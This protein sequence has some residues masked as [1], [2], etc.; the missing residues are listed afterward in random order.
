MRSDAARDARAQAPTDPMI[1]YV[2]PTHRGWEVVMPDRR[3]PLA[4]ETLHEARRVAH[5]HLTHTQGYELIVHDAYHRVLERELIDRR[6][7]PGLGAAK[8]RSLPHTQTISTH[9]GGQ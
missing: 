4:C 3:E 6:P 7:F 9:Q 2:N 8:G 1:V 5:L